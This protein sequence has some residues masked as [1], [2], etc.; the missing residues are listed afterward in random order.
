MSSNISNYFA[1]IYC[2]LLN[3]V[4]PTEEFSDLCVQI[5]LMV[6]QHSLLQVNRIT[7]DLVRKALKLMKSSKRDALFDIQS[8]CLI[9]GPPAL[10]THLTNLIRTF[11]LHGSIPHYILLCTLLPLVK[12]NLADTTSADNY[13]A[14]ASGSLLLK[15]LDLVIL[16]LEGDKL[17][18]D[19]LQFGFQPG[20]GT[21]MCTW[22]ATAVIDYFNRRGNVVYGSKQS[23]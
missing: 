1:G 8:D 6:G 17:Y 14:I 15:L 18:C 13:R 12:D 9:N 19:Q 4:L 10:V 3:K 11:V 2:E 21:V 7:E 22:T 23:F 20:S 16:S 5:N